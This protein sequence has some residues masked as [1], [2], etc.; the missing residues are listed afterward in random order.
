[1]SVLPTCVSGYHMPALVPYGGQMSNYRTAEPGVTDGCG[2]AC[3]CQE[4]T[5]SAIIRLACTLNH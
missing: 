5:P 3:G 2:L 4:L 1:M